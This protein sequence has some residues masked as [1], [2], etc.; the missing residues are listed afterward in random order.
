MFEF[1]ESQIAVMKRTA[2]SEMNPCD[3]RILHGAIGL[4]TES[5]ELMEC[6][7]DSMFVVPSKIVGAP[8]KRKSIDRLNLVEEVGDTLWYVALL[9]DALG[10]TYEQLVKLDRLPH[11]EGFPNQIV[12][13]YGV[14]QVHISSCVLM[15]MLK[16]Q[17]YYNRPL[18]IERF[19][20]NLADALVGLGFIVRG[21]DT[22]I[23]V[24]V[25]V[26]KA[27]L[28]SRYK[29]EYTDDQANERDLEQERQIISMAFQK[30]QKDLLPLKQK[31]STL[32]I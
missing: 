10:I 4:V 21:I 17:I 20:Q 19:T 32:K 14:Q 11:L 2:K 28:E 18:D 25:I 7:H 31:G 1:F 16:C 13:Q 12:F 6:V 26:N 23:E 9:V 3:P 22:S 30:A 29:D 27:K 24:C 15:D 5:G 8:P